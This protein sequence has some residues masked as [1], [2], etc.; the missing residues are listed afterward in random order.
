MKIDDLEI[1]PMRIDK[2]KKDFLLIL[3]REYEYPIGEI[4]LGFDVFKRR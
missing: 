1:I 3:L 4:V 2:N